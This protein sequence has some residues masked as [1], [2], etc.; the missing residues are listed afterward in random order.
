MNFIQRMK[1][2]KELRRLESRVREEP[3]PSRFVDLGQVYINLEMLDRALQ[4]AEDGLALF[5]DS[6]ELTKLRDFARR[7]RIACQRIHQQQHVP[8]LVAEM[9]GDRRRVDG[10]LHARQ[11][12]RVAGC[13]D[14]DRTPD[15]FVAENVLDELLDFAPALAD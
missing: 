11:R 3:S 14:D 4:A 10:A 9:F 2:R 1:I 5:P 7:H 6:I 15:P 12:R 13:G 8:A